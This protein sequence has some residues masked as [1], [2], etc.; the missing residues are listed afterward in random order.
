MAT[1]STNSQ[2]AA[3]KL[4]I[5]DKLYTAFIIPQIQTKLH[6]FD[7]KVVKFA[8]S[9]EHTKNFDKLYTAFIIA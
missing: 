1:R 6:E 9:S 8:K 7:D 5:S 2:K 4:K 3:D